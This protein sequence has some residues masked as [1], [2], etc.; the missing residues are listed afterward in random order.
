[1]QEGRLTEA[2]VSGE[3]WKEEGSLKQARNGA[4]PGDYL[5]GGL[6]GAMWSVEL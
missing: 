6:K 5:D 3:L 1:M 2:Q 4:W